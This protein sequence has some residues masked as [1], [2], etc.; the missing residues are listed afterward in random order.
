MLPCKGQL[1]DRILKKVTGTNLGAGGDK[2]RRLPRWRGFESVQE[3][4][5]SSVGGKKE[6]LETEPCLSFCVVA[7]CSVIVSSLG[8]LGKLKRPMAEVSLCPLEEAG[9]EGVSGD[10]EPGVF[11]PDVVDMF[12]LVMD[13]R[14]C[15]CLVY[16]MPSKR[17]SWKLKSKVATYQ[18]KGAKWMPLTQSPLDS[19]LARQC[20]RL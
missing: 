11:G 6:M 4:P 14:C 15:Y 7:M 3:T 1:V 8:L 9:E 16:S 10:P 19:S 12:C 18:K 17:G 20:R 5:G 13:S 2:V